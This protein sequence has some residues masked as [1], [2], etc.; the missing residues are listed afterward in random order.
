MR[1]TLI[2]IQYAAIAVA[3][4]ALFVVLFTIGD[5]DVG[6][7]A[8]APPV[9]LICAFISALGATVA[10]AVQWIG[11]PPAEEKPVPSSEDSDS[12]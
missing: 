6:P 11:L 10:G 12:K 2:V 1:K 3:V 4:A 8:P 5:T 7:E 9:T